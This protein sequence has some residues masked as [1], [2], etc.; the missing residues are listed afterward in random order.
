MTGLMSAAP[1]CPACE[2]TMVRRRRRA[3]GAASGVAPTIPAAAS[4]LPI[5]D[6]PR[7]KDEPGGSAGRQFAGRRDRHKAAVEAARGTVLRRGALIFA[8]GLAARSRRW[9][10]DLAA[11][12]GPF[13]SAGRVAASM[14]P[15]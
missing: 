11:L 7:Q 8:V 13:H 9:S 1:S 12:H 2:T 14:T 3:D 15:P 10:C 5:G 6:G 4:P